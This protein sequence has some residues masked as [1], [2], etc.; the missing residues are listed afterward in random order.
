MRMAEQRVEGWQN[1]EQF[2]GEVGEPYLSASTAQLNQLAWRGCGR[3]RVGAA[4]AE[5]A[6]GR[7]R[8]LSRLRRGNAPPTLSPVSDEL[9]SK[10]WRA[11]VARTAD[12]APMLSPLFVAQQGAGVQLVDLRDSREAAGFLGHVAG[13]AFLDPEQVPRD[14]PPFART[15]HLTPRRGGPWIF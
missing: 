6:Q 5:D 15:R 8:A 14:V 2:L 9:F 3:S 1:R 11:S 4:G 13:S 10:R 7:C 12:G